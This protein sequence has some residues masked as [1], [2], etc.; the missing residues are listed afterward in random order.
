MGSVLICTL[1]C[2]KNF[3]F[4]KKNSHEIGSWFI[5]GIYSPTIFKNYGITLANAKCLGYYETNKIDIRLNQQLHVYAGVILPIWNRGSFDRFL[6][7]WREMIV[8][9]NIFSIT[10][11]PWARKKGEMGQSW[12]IISPTSPSKMIPDMKSL[13]LHNLKVIISYSL[14]S[15]FKSLEMVDPLRAT[16][17]D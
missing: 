9:W 11:S 4:Q 6:Y 17:P 1:L 5:S 10:T 16:K 8:F 15:V 13:N 2:L 14:C 3:P 12:E 7:F